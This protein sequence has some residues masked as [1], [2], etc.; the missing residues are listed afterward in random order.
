MT[1]K[2]LRASFCVLLALLAGCSSL[3]PLLSP[4]TP[5]PVLTAAS[6]PQAIPTST[7]P[8][9]D[10]S[11]LLRVWLPPRFDPD[12]GSS[13]A[14]LLKGRLLDFE[15]EYP[16]IRVEVRIKSETDILNALAVT[17]NAAPEA[18]PDLVALS[19]TDMR[20]AVSA[21]L[22]HSFDGLT[23]L[24]QDPDWYAFAREL[25]KLQD[26]EYGI[27][28]AG[29]LLL[30]VYRPAVFEEPPSAWETLI[31]SNVP[32]AFPAADP[33]ALFS[34]TLYLSEGAQTLNNQGGVVLDEE[35][36]L[37]LLFFQ[38][39]AIEAGT[40]PRSIM[41]HQTD[42]QSLQLYR[43]G[44]ADLAI[45][46]A[47]S[48][49]PTPGGRYAP[50][51]GLNNLLYSLGDGWVWALA[52]SD[53]ENQPLAVELASYLVES[54]YMSEWTRAAGYLPTRPQALAEWDDED[55]K[56]SIGEA[57]RSAHPVPSEESLSVMGPLLQEALIRL[58][59][60]EQPEAVARSVIES[61]K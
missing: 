1:A 50:L 55:L 48:D 11:R 4:P 21:G 8:V 27:P 47:S 52:G 38:K 18:M 41:D 53:L 39:R 15:S 17:N 9:T 19:H 6:T 10:Q 25:G 20:A 43:A 58:Y 42:E 16:G 56:N 3:A 49:L 23:T 61:A 37:Q 22:L 24:P 35:S 14:E 2:V 34:L 28:F 31:E 30:A 32:L 51:P 26:I 29:D 54:S 60:G 36:L 13:S 7:A 40:F 45:V 33:K 59:N 5:V 44:G 12:A 57:L 46:W